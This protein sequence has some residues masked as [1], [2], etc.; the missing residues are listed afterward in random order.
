MYQY[1]ELWRMKSF[2]CTY[3]HRLMWYMYVYAY[4]HH[5]HGLWWLKSNAACTY[6]Y[7]Q[8]YKTHTYIYI[9]THTH[10]HTHTYRITL[11][12]MLVLFVQPEI[13]PNST[14]YILYPF[15]HV[16]THIITQCLRTWSGSM[17]ECVCVYVYVYIYIYIYISHII[18]PLCIHTRNNSVLEAPQIK[19]MPYQREVREKSLLHIVK[20]N[21][22]S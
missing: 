19:I 9:R 11:T 21:E 3:T 2:A 4:M 22:P 20:H 15:V 1:H 7:T 10:S 5:Y 18:S 8:T 16:Y 17:Y 12:L 14:A 13:P 6:I